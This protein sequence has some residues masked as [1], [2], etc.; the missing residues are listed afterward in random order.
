[1]GQIVSCISACTAAIDIL[2]S[3][4]EALCNCE[5]RVRFVRFIYCLLIIRIDKRLF[6]FIFIIIIFF[7]FLFYNCP[8][9]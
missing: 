6:E 9:L 3:I 4:Q 7:T 2:H 8:R 1:M 5:I